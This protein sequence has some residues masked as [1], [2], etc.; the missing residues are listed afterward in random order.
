MGAFME[1][2]DTFKWEFVTS[3][4]VVYLAINNPGAWSGIQFAAATAALWAVGDGKADLHSM[5][6][7][8]KAV[9]TAETPV[10]EA[11]V[12]VGGQFAGAFVAAVINL[13]LNGVVTGPPI[14]GPPT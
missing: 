9:I 11:A 14:P 3:W 7:F 12:R 6:T 8:T 4:F 2:L 5:V 10:A 1:N 13:V